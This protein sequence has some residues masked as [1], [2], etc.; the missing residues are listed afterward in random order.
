[1]RLETLGSNSTD[2]DSV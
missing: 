1:M 2:A